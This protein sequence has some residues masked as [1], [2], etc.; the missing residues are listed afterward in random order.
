DG[1]DNEIF[2][3]Q[4]G[5][6]TVDGADNDDT[7]LAYGDTDGVGDGADDTF[8]GGTGGTDLDLVDYSALSGGVT[9]SLVEGGDG[10]VTGSSV[11]TDT[12]TDVEN[13]IGSSGD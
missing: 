8:Y 4:P 1:D 13:A 12:I 5:T 2:N 9:I 7:W 6:Q 10:S 3:D 11:G